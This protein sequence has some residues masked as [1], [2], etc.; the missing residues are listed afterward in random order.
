MCWQVKPNHICCSI[1]LLS[2]GGVSGR[3]KIQAIK[4]LI[5][6]QT[7]LVRTLEKKWRG[8]IVYDTLWLPVVPRWKWAWLSLFGKQGPSGSIQIPFLVYGLIVS[9]WH[10][11][12]CLRLLFFF[13]KFAVVYCFQ[14]DFC[15]AFCSVIFYLLFSLIQSCSL[16][17]L[18]RI[19]SHFDGHNLYLWWKFGGSCALVSFCV[20]QKSVFSF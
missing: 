3:S 20:P 8:K 2:Y 14:S 17:L 7:S 5:S 15:L 18:V 4:L 10:S 6:Q 13:L 11:S 16:G 12:L 1:L 19:I 9:R